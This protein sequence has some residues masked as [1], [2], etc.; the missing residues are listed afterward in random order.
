MNLSELPASSLGAVLGC[1]GTRDVC[2]ARGAC[3]RWRNGKPMWRRIACEK[4]PS[5]V[6]VASIRMCVPAFVHEVQGK[7]RMTDRGLVYVG[8]LANLR[9]L[10]FWGCDVT[11]AGL[12][13]LASARNLQ[14]LNLAWCTKVKDDGLMYIAALT[15]LKELNLEGSNVTDA[16]IEHL[17]AIASLEALNLSWTK[18]ADV[19]LAHIATLSSL[20]ILDVGGGNMTDAGL[21]HIVACPSLETLRLAACTRVTAAGVAHLAAMTSLQTLCL[22]Q[23]TSVNDAGLLHLASLPNLTQLILSPNDGVTTNG[24][25]LMQAAR[26]AQGF[27]EIALT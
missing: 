7:N 9:K 15:S 18:V 27:N 20:K 26:V 4:E 1:L 2:A 10:T 11:A 23:C 12:A 17:T 13:H 19:G 3:H 22:R 8:A 21:A 14:E 5:A 24:V 16:G 25:E 6:F